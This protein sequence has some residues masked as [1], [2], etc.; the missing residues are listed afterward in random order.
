MKVENITLASYSGGMEDNM[1]VL[2]IGGTGLISAAVSELAVQQGIDLY[3]LNRGNRNEF[4][5][6]GVTFIKADINNVDEVKAALI[7][8]HFD[9]VV[10]WIAFVPE[11]IQRDY[12]LFSEITSQYI[13]ISSA[14]VYQKP[15]THY[16]ITESTPLCNPYWEYSRNKIACEELLMDLYRSNGFPITIVRPSHTYGNPLIPTALSSWKSCY[17][18]IHRMKQ[19]KPIV[20][21][22]DGSSLWTMT[23]NTDFAKGFVGLLANIQT[24]GHA[25]HITSDEVLNWDQIHQVIGNAINVKPNL[26]HIPSD[27]IIRFQPEQEGSLLGDKSPSVVFDNSKIKLFVPSFT[28]TMPL[29]EGVKRSILWHEADPSRCQHDLEWDATMDKMISSYE[30]GYKK[31]SLT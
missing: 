13:F 7:G 2:F 9:A 19:G 21:H 30:K 17:A 31:R 18:I 15:Q 6:V 1:K 8:H 27:F 26:F 22:G 20:V 25:F 4:T 11:Q 12:K 10:N 23:H 28:A 5:P 29:S 16:L 24:I 14:S 3:L